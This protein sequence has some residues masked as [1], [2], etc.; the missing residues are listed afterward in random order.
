[1]T[2]NQAMD[3]Y[4]QP[5]HLYSHSRSCTRS[6]LCR[7]PSRLVAS[8]ICYLFDRASVHEISALV[9]WFQYMS[10]ISNHY[11]NL[12]LLYLQPF[13]R[14]W[15]FVYLHHGDS[16]L[17]ILYVAMTTYVILYHAYAWPLYSYV[18]GTAICICNYV[19]SCIIVLCW[20]GGWSS[21]WD[22]S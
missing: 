21:I 18:S 15:S 2:G 10:D 6:G 3:Y 1:M 20:L 22:P 13:W 16:D 8:L 9:T 17:F 12:D 11:G 19:Q 5:W 14:S 4:V 7:R